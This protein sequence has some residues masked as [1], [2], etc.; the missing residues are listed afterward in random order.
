MIKVQQW[1]AVKVSDTTTM[2]W[3]TNACPKK[4][5]TQLSSLPQP[6]AQIHRFQIVISSIF[7]VN[8][9]LVKRY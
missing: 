2:T 5:T 4:T 8:T 7:L 9:Y 6:V 1:Y 3:K